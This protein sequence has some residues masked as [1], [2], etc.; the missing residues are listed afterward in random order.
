M[1]LEIKPAKVPAPAVPVG[2]EPLAAAREIDT[3]VRTVAQRRNTDKIEL[4][5]AHGFDHVIN[6]RE[7]DVAARVQAIDTV[8]IAGSG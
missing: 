7:E 6:Y 2:A 4:A 3:Q 8:R 5:K 1:R